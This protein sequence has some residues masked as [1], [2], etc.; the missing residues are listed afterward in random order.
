MLGIALRGVGDLSGSTAKGLCR[1]VHDP[2][3][4]SSSKRDI[5]LMKLCL[6]SPFFFPEMSK[7]CGDTVLRDM[8]SGQYQW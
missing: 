8:A 6:S 2:C 4:Y 5:N 1:S 7:K 3:K